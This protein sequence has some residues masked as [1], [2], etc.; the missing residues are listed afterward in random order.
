MTRILALVMAGGKGK[1]LYPLTAEHAKPAL[2]FAR[3]YRIIDFVLSNLVNSGISEIYVLAQYKPRSLLEYLDRSWVS[4]RDGNDVRVSTVVPAGGERFRGTADAIYQ[5]L[6]L[7]ER[8][9]P[10]L[11]A[12]F[13][14]D[15][16]YRMDV[17][18]MAAYHLERNAAVSV[19]AIPVPI[20]KASSLGVM[21]T[22]DNGAICEFQEKPHRPATIP[23]DPT[24][25]YA[26]MGNYLFHPGVLTMLLKEAIDHG[27]C[28]FG[29]HILPALPGR[30]PVYA[31]D[32]SQN[33]V[34]GIA[35]HET[36]VYWR[37]VGTVEELIAAQKDILGARPRFSLYNSAWPLHG[38]DRAR[39][40]RSW[41]DDMRQ[42]ISARTDPRR[43]ANVVG[44]KET[45][46]LLNAGS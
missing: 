9:Q 39:A 12:V 17:R 32:F 28:D 4:R 37:D 22:G 20:D 19:A 21:V 41:H 44:N 38:G 26:S 23:G 34:P 2:H 27:G 46:A 24:R 42:K 5:N 14:A 29:H 30:F 11:V 31:Y 33:K 1:R 16:I 40:E 35:P 6:H 7:I 45:G 10:D 25:A 18:Q 13:A 15:H 36:S 43:A 3:G 8:H